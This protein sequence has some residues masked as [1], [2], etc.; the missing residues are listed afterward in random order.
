MIYSI[1]FA[2]QVEINTNYAPNAR[3]AYLN[4][5]AINYK[6]M[7]VNI[8]DQSFKENLCIIMRRAI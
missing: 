6:T 5:V 7:I 1:Q 2:F 4:N 3:Y 8:T